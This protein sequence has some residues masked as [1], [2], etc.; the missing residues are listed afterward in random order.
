MSINTVFYIFY[1]IWVDLHSAKRESV[2]ISD[3]IGMIDTKT[4]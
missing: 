3:Q 1:K 2:Q 4:S